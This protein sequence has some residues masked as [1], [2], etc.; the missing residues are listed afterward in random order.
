LRTSVGL[1]AYGQRDPLIE[2]QKEGRLMFE[3]LVDSIERQVIELIDNLSVGAFQKE[4]ERLKEAV[5]NAQ[6]IT[7]SGTILESE[8]R[9]VEGKKYGRNDLVTIQKGEETMEV[10]YKKA[11]KMF[12]EG[13]QIKD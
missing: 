1:R 4:E 13:W 6:L 10:K 9:I 3:G 7:S 11:E 12:A 5:K 2:Y 8:K